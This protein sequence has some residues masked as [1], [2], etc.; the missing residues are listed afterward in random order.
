MAV[1][2]SQQVE[3]EEELIFEIGKAMQFSAE[4]I[5]EFI[6][7]AFMGLQWQLKSASLLERYTQPSPQPSE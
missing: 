2:K 6:D 5:N 7:W 4:E 1:V 3:K